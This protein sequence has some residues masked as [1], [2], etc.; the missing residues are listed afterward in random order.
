MHA[1]ASHSSI[2]KPDAAYPHE[3]YTD[4]SLRSNAD[5]ITLF[6]KILKTLPLHR[7]QTSDVCRIDEIF[8]KRSPNGIEFLHSE[9]AWNIQ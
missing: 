2:V 3:V 8:L 1:K 9:L 5:V 6:R 7:G 4:R